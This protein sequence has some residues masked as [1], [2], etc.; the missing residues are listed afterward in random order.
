MDL[1]F[2]DQ[3]K[4]GKPQNEAESTSPPLPPEELDAGAPRSATASHT[5][6]TGLDENEAPAADD[7]NAADDHAEDAP[8]TLGADDTEERDAANAVESE[9]GAGDVRTSFDRGK[10][11]GAKGVGFF[12]G[13]PPDDNRERSVTQLH[14]R[15]L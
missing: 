8:L 11:S 6:R 7:V 13:E 3:S 12:I 15:C 14:D 9:G 10:D 1:F 2:D 4:R 5:T